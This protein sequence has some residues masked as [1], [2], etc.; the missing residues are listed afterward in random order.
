MGR[1][2]RTTTAATPAP[3]PRLRFKIREALCLLPD[4]RRAPIEMLL[5]MVN[6]L[7]PVPVTLA[8]LRDPLA[9]NHD[10]GFVNFHHNLDLE[11]DEWFITA[12]GRVK[13]AQG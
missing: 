4:G 7:I 2:T 9:W 13:Q 10:R 12:Q 8:D 11:R 1:T 6:D 5:G 3:D